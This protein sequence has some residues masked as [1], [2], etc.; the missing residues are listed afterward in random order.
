[1]R[2]RLSGAALTA[3]VVLVAAA[4]RAHPLREAPLEVAGFEDYVEAAGT[5]IDGELHVA[6]EAREAVWRPWGDDGATVYTHV[7]VVAGEAARMPAP[8]IRVTAGTP[9]R[10]TIRNSFDLPLVVRGFQD[11]ALLPATAQ[12]APPARRRRCRPAGAS[13]SASRRAC[14]AHTSTVVVCR[15]PCPPRIRCRAPARRTAGCWAW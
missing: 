2:A 7:F 6:L 3:A 8:M 4:V 10:V 13:R 15:V 1:M 14:R 12:G 11:H 5:L 9:V